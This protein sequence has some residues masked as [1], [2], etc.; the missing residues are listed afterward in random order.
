MNKPDQKTLNSPEALNRSYTA[1]EIV[2]QRERTLEALEIRP[3]EAILDIGCGTGFLTF[4]LARAT[5]AAGSVIGVDPDPA[6]V[7][8]T[9]ERCADLDQVS[10]EIGDAG[11]LPADDSS[12]DVV[13]CTQVLLYVEDVPGALSEIHRVLKPG[14]RVAIL[15][16]DWR[17]L[18]LNSEDPALTRTIADAWDA[19][20]ASP[21]LPRKLGP[22]LR[23]SGF[24]VSHCEAIP[25]LNA[26]Y[27]ENSFS[28]STVEWLAKN[29]SRQGAIT[30]EQGIEWVEGLNRLASSGAWFFCLN[31]FLFVATRP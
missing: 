11:Y 16:T 9:L 17:G 13:T 7:S 8:S 6:M 31:R 20:T 10:A 3:A 5:G 28:A 19:T 12:I 23:E 21:N 2:N 14:G 29:A 4:E 1:P 25:L 22:L 30:K 18:I 15:E 27:S 26:G 24:S